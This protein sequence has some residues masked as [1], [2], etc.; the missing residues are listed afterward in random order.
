M[1]K[2]VLVSFSIGKYEDVFIQKKKKY[3]DEVLCEVVPM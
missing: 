1:N 2:Q 3:E